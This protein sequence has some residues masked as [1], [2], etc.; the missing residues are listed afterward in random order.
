LTQYGRSMMLRPAD[1]DRTCRRFQSRRALSMKAR[2]SNRKRSG[3]Q[4]SSTS[5]AS[6]QAAMPDRTS[7]AD[8]SCW[9]T[10][11]R[12]A[13]YV[14]SRPRTECSSPVASGPTPGADC[15]G[16]LFAIALI[17]TS[18]TALCRQARALHGIACAVGRLCH[19][20]EQIIQ[21]HGQSTEV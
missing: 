8:R 14:P 19:T 5:H 9:Y 11:G 13:G 10:S 12:S 2:R 4:V 20:R 17:S 1:Q 6:Y 15:P 16:H 21:L 18:C 3:L 7:P